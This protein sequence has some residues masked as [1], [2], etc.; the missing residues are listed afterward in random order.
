VV[1]FGLVCVEALGFMDGMSGGYAVAFVVFFLM[2]RGITV[3]GLF[4]HRA[5]VLDAIITS[6]QLLAHWTDPTETARQKAL[7][8]NIPTTS[9]RT[10][11]C[12][13][14]SGGC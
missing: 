13:S 14:L 11:P 1:V 7:C 2:A 6:H 3:A 12:S 4:L 9:T 8:A 10:E 5:R